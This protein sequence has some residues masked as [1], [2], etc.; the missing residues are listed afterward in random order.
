[1]TKRFEFQSNNLELDIAGN[2]F[3]VDTTNPELVERVLKFSSEAKKLAGEM[4]EKTDFTAALKETIE[5]CTDAIDSILGTGASKKIFEGRK[6][7][8]F[9]CL[10]IINF[11]VTEVKDHRQSKFQSYSPNRAQRRAK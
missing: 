11:I 10:D 8:L 9:D 5:F 7:G 2:I 3:E 6:V 1:M 4:N